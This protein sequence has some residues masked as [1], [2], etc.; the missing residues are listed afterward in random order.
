MPWSEPAVPPARKPL[1]PVPMRTATVAGQI[2]D[3]E[4]WF[5]LR[6]EVAQRDGNHPGIDSGERGGYP[7]AKRAVTGARQNGNREAVGQSD[8]EIEVSVLVE[9]G[10]DNGRGL[11]L[12]SEGLG[13]DK[14]AAR[15]PEQT[16]D[17]SG[18]ANHKVGEAIVVEVGR[19]DGAGLWQVDAGNRKKSRAIEKYVL[20]WDRQ[21]S[22]ENADEREALPHGHSERGSILDIILFRERSVLKLRRLPPDL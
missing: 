20:R 4:V 2:T 7:L 17:G 1:A 11:P 9:I 14:L 15:L 13:L 8:R 16:D 10:G 19:E 5:A 21:R 3:G 12:D 6:I 22:E 18:A